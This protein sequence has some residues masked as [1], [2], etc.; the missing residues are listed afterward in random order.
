MFDVKNVSV[1]M[2]DLCNPNRRY[3]LKRNASG[4]GI[5][6][7]AGGLRQREELRQAQR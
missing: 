1:L 7:T 3:T 5:P 6:Q 2:C 4:K